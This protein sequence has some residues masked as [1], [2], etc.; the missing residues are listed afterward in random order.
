MTTDQELT[1]VIRA[2]TEDG[3]RTGIGMCV[4]LMDL[5]IRDMPAEQ[6]AE[7]ALTFMRDLMRTT[8]AEFTLEAAGA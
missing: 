4:R 2:A 6:T 5:A 8:S 7:Q 1:K 3:V